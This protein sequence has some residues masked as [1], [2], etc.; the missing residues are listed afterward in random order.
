MIL[1]EPIKEYDEVWHD[2]ATGQKF[3]LGSEFVSYAYMEKVEEVQLIVCCCGA[4]GV[5]PTH[6]SLLHIPFRDS[7]YSEDQPSIEWL[8]RAIRAAGELHNG[9]NIFVHCAEG[10]NRSAL[11][12][13]LYLYEYHRESFPD[14]MS[15]IVRHLREKRQRGLLQNS[16]FERLLA[17]WALANKGI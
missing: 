9:K 10:R 13:A 3:F 2:R 17:D 4:S 5:P 15:Q 11:F 7:P 8:I 6:S 16:H 14:G 12:L 1:T